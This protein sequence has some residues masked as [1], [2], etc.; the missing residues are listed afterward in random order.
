MSTSRTLA[1]THT[2][3]TTLILGAQPAIEWQKCLGG[4]STEYLNA[5][6]K[7]A[8]GG[9]FVAGWT[10]S[11]DGDASGHHGGTFPPYDAWVVK[12]DATSTIEWQKCLG[13]TN[14]ERANAIAGTSDGGC[15]MAGFSWSNDGDVI[16]NSGVDAWVVK[17]DPAGALVA[18][19]CLG[20]SSGDI[21]RAIQETP[22]GG[23]VLAGSTASNDG[24]LSG[25]HGNS[26]GWI[27]K[28]DADAV[29]QWQH[30]LGGSAYDALWS[31][32]QTNDGGY[33]VAGH[34]YSND[35]DVIGQHGSKDAWVLR[36]NSSGAI[37]WQK[38]MGG[39]GEDEFTTVLETLDG[40]FILVG[41]T[42][43]ND[44]DVTLLH[45]DTL[46]D[47][48]VVK[49]NAAGDLQWQR[50]LGGSSGDFARSVRQ[51]ANGGYIV[52]GSTGSNDGDVSGLHEGS[53]GP[54]DAWVVKLDAAGALEWQKCLGGTYGE[55]ANAI[56]EVSA[57]RYVLAG[58]TMS[59]DGDVTGNHGAVD[60]WVVKLGPAEV[61]VAEEPRPLF[62][63]T[64]NPTS[65]II[66]V[67][68]PRSPSVQ[69]L[70]LL[71]ATGRTIIVQPTA[72][73]A[74]SLTVDLTGQESG[75]YLVQLRFAD[76]T[77]AVERVVK[78]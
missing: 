71:D 15:L 26:D 24:D 35:G 33:V 55:T 6:A 67:T 3:L 27:A 50:S 7:A 73:H 57:E 39:S 70:L 62:T 66:T 74:G 69:E 32:Q 37:Q 21:G 78:E 64:P 49:L 47:A 65:S 36:L 52:A 59:N 8:N 40:G 41:S 46:T 16:G 68:L 38:C 12:L 11:N 14:E 2:L 48:W 43:S 1:I 28:L 20:G 22:D 5:L 34:S 18:Q 61:G 54:S 77:R 23:F 53:T 75:M 13:G 60:G 25:N 56:E 30:C 17:L 72:T 42:G 19:H 9:Y 51:T 58:G 45:A 31:V 10:T 76:G 29:I 44:G 63:L 4:S